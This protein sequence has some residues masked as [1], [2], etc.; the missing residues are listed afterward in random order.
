M[1]KIMPKPTLWHTASV[2]SC[3]AVACSTVTLRDRL[4]SLCTEVLTSA[5]LIE[6]AIKSLWKCFCRVT[7]GTVNDSCEVSG[8]VSSG[9][10]LLA[11]PLS[12]FRPWYLGGHIQ[13]YVLSWLTQVAP[14]AH[15]PG[16]QWSTT[17]EITPKTVKSPTR[18]AH[19]QISF[20]L[21]SL[22]GNTIPVYFFQ[23]SSW[24]KQKN[25]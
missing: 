11:L 21:L 7:N 2:V 14:F 12:Q 16:W 19:N 18:T 13:I 10:Q 5:I 20:Y 3:Q 15:R 9:L 1:L 4:C 17:A 22:T 8:W 6:T 24:K 23:N 25:E